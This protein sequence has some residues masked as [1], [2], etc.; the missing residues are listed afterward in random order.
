MGSS[1]K[2]PAENGHELRYQTSLDKD[3]T[4]ADAKG[5]TRPETKE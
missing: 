1:T 2:R 4:I 5:N 3:S